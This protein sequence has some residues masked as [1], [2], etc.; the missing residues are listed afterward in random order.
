MSNHVTECLNAYLDG[1]LH[2]RYLQ[3]VE[4]HLAECQVCQAELESLGRLSSFLQE[5]PEPLFTSP[6]RFAAQVSLCLP[7]RKPAVSGKKLLEVGWWMIP[8][9]LLAT[10]IFISKSYFVHVMLTMANSFGLL[11]SVSEWIRFGTPNAANWSAA[12]KQ[13][14][15]LSGE[16][17][18]WMASTEA[19]TR[20]SL[21]EISFQISIALLYLSWLAIWWV[22]HWRQEN[23]PLLEG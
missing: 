16:T 11:T 2:G 23:S 5:I 17:F 14:G 9:G 4:V 1:E 22:R 13:V 15:L 21:S 8:V 19:I 10:W 6:E 12:L 18:N 3:L 20:T 7:Q